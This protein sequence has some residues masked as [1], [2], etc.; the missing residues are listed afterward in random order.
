MAI[1]FVYFMQLYGRFVKLCWDNDAEIPRFSFIL[2]RFLFPNL[3][4]NDFPKQNRIGVD[5]ALWKF[6]GLPTVELALLMKTEKFRRLVVV[7]FFFY[8]YVLIFVFVCSD[9]GETL[10]FI[11]G[12][13]KR[14]T[15]GPWTGAKMSRGSSVTYVS[16]GTCRKVVVSSFWIF[17]FV[18]L[19]RWLDAK[20]AKNPKSR[21]FF[22]KILL[23]LRA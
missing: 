17:F 18:S 16:E 10:I 14:T 1:V 11:L 12:N 8:Q 2:V 19:E 6:T 23:I 9:G 3:E 13:Q 20:T 5:G 21:S 4:K 22:A 15:G 7:M